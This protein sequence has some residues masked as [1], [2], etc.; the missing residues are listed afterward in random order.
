MKEQ[1]IS[2]EDRGIVII[3]YKVN[4]IESVRVFTPQTKILPNSVHTRT[5]VPTAKAKDCRTTAFTDCYALQEVFSRSIA[6]SVVV[7]K[8]QVAGYWKNT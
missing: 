7:L 8:I 4:P 2:S 1:D 5:H 6:K 3:E